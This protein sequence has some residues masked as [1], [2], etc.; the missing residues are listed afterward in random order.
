[1]ILKKNKVIMLPD[2]KTYYKATIIKT[3]WDLSKYRQINGKKKQTPELEPLIH[4]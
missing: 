4:K 3:D 1:M 2:L